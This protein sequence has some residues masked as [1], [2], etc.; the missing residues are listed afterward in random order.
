ME[1]EC[2]EGIGEHVPQ[3]HNARHFTIVAT[4][5]ASFIT[6]ER[7]NYCTRLLG[8]SRCNLV[9]FSSR[10]PTFGWCVKCLFLTK[11]LAFHVMAQSLHHWF[12]DK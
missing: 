11:G 6:L 2:I 10:T 7:G 5:F 1:L 8:M 9:V 12:F 3:V 4:L